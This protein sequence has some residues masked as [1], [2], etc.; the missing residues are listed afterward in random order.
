MGEIIG[1]I[2][3][4]FPVVHYEVN[5]GLNNISMSHFSLNKFIREF[6]IVCI[7]AVVKHIIRMGMSWSDP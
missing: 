5:I 3:T 6:P 4:D 1:S 7:V 2:N